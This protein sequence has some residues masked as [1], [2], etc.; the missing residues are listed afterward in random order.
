VLDANFGQCRLSSGFEAHGLLSLARKFRTAMTHSRESLFEELI[1]T[2]I[3]H[4]NWSYVDQR[5]W[6]VHGGTGLGNWG[7]INLLH[8]FRH[9]KCTIRRDRIYSLLALAKKGKT[10]TS[11]RKIMRQV[12]SVRES[13]ICLCSTAIVA[14]ALAPWNFE[15]IKEREGNADFAKLNMYAIAWSS[16]ACSFCAHWVPF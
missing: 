7:I 15:A 1:D 11:W 3:V 4:K 13:S 16:M 2:R 5:I 14:H 10:M 8:R 12:L 6:W 9:K